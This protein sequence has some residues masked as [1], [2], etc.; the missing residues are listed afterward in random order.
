VVE[1]E[2]F[3]EESALLIGGGGGNSSSAWWV[4]INY[5]KMK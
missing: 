2:S 4:K 3:S 1:L 5:A